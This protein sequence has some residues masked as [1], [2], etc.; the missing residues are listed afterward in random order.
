MRVYEVCLHFT[1]HMPAAT[2]Q[3]ETRKLKSNWAVVRRNCNQYLNRLVCVRES[4]CSSD[5]ICLSGPCQNDCYVI[6][7]V[8]V[9]VG[10]TNVVS[11]INIYTPG[12]LF[13]GVSRLNRIGRRRKS[14]RTTSVNRVHFDV[15]TNKFNPR[16]PF[17]NFNKCDSH[18]IYYSER[19]TA[20]SAFRANMNKNRR[21]IL[22][23]LG[24]M[25]SKSINTKIDFN[26]FCSFTM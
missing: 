1:L 3:Y 5:W 15:H 10:R 11:S 16:N 6:F 14:E 24:C 9:L 7:V 12:P 4:M 17:S 2:N 25:C 8:V 18:R 21:N 19:R 13:D 26:L 23:C 22:R 20:N